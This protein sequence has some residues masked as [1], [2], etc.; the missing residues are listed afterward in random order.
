M[1]KTEKRE[2][3]SLFPSDLSDFVF[4]P[5]VH[6]SKLSSAYKNLETSLYQKMATLTGKPLVN[7]YYINRNLVQIVYEVK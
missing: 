4:C 7:N 1:K 5:C 3:S 2:K 6:A